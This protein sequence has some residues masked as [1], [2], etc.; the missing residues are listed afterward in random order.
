MPDH[1]TALLYRTLV[2]VPIG[3]YGAGVLRCFTTPIVQ[4]DRGPWPHMSRS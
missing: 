4:S 3:G 1:A 2:V